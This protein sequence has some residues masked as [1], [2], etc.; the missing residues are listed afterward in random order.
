MA[1]VKDILITTSEYRPCYV[2]DRKALFHKWGYSQRVVPPSLLK[3]GHSGGTI[4]TTYGIVEYEDGKVAEVYPSD[5]RFVDNK[6]EGYAFGD[7]DNTKKEVQ[8]DD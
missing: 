6:L 5:I 1:S 2:G 7:E 8:E 3:G 4:S